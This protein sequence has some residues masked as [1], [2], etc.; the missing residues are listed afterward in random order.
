L[1]AQGHVTTSYVLGYIGTRAPLYVG[2]FTIG[3]DRCPALHNIWCAYEAFVASLF[4]GIATK[5]GG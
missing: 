3:A 2:V 5:G 4:L 1:L